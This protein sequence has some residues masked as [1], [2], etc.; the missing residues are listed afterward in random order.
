M[1]AHH[2]KA[3][4]SQYVILHETRKTRSGSQMPLVASSRVVALDARNKRGL[5]Q[6]RSS[7]LCSATELPK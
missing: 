4:V 7:G 2:V 5:N 6:G 1:V 3:K